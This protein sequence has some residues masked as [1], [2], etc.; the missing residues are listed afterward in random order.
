M[1]S[2]QSGFDIRCEWGSEGLKN[3]ADSCSSLII[4]DVLSFCT[5]IDVCIARGALVYPYPHKTDTAHQFA[6]DKNATLA[7]SERS[8]HKY[9]LSPTSLKEIP[10]GTRLVLP[11]P[12]GSALSFAA[13]NIPTFAA[14]L[15][16]A[17]A[18]ASAAQ[19]IGGPICIIAAGETWENGT[20][21]PA[22]EDLVGAGAVVDALQGS[23]SP[24]AELA[25]ASF[26]QFKSYLGAFLKSCTSGQELAIKG[27]SDD[28][29]LAAALNS[30]SCVPYLEDGA[31]RNFIFEH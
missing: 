14:C 15:R 8:T 17:R 26:W 22:A 9:S 3:L 11:S 29:E 25:C 4:I 5:A 28:I 30:S 27:F 20:L 31:F 12:N 24:E 16:N 13:P 6:G 7:S 21:R 1:T 10:P 18:V 23:K 2:Q 19:Q